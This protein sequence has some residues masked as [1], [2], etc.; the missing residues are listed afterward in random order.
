MNSK[1]VP[2]V[3]LRFENL[4][5]LEDGEE[6]TKRVPLPSLREDSHI[7]GGFRLVIGG[8]VVP[9]MG[10]FGADDVCFGDWLT[11][12]DGVMEAFAADEVATYVY[13]EGEQ[14]QPAF[15]FE[16]EGDVAFLS[17]ADSKIS[18]GEAHPDWQR[19]V[20]HYTDL[21]DE[22]AHF[23]AD[24][25]DEVRRAAPATGEKWLKRFRSA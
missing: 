2:T 15:V 21:R 20:F 25:A 3:T 1:P 17:I 5:V 19:A 13:D 14:G 6:G 7:H 16:R 12:L 23:R 10:Y 22:Y 8:R 24:F 4:A 18:D 11:E 9:Y